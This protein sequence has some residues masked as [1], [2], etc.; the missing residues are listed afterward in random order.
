[1]TGI[2][3]EGEVVGR[4]D[5]SGSVRILVNSNSFLTLVMEGREDEDMLLCSIFQ[6]SDIVLGHLVAAF[7]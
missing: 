3:L 7:L 1:M 6:V 2:R 4:D 5:S